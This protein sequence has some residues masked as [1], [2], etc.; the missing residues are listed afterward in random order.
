[1]H[2]SKRTKL[3]IFLLILSMLSGC[4]L[5]RPAPAAE[6]AESAAQTPEATEPAPAQPAVEPSA[7]P[8]QIEPTQVPLEPVSEQ[9]PKE[10][11]PQTDPE[12]ARSDGGKLIV[13]DPGHQ[14][15]GNYATEPLGPGSAE[16]KAKVSGGTAGVS[17]GLAEHELTLQV[18]LLLR[19]ELLARGYAVVLTR[20]T[21]DVDLSNVERAKIAND[22]QAD[23]FVRIHANGSEN[24]GASGAMTICMTKNSPYHPE[25]YDASYAL[26]AAI[27]DA[28]TAETGAKREYIWETDT[29]SGINWSE[30]P[31]TI[32]EMGYMTNPAEDRLLASAPYQA[33]IVT[34]IADGLDAYFSEP[35]PAGNDDPAEQPPQTDLQMLVQSELDALSSKWDVWVEDLSDGTS[36][37][38]FRNI[39]DGQSMVSASLIKLFIMGAVFDRIEAG[40]IAESEVAD[41]LYSM[42]TVSDNDAANSL[43]YLLGSGD[44]AEGRQAV[45]AWA[46]SIDCDDVRYN[47]LMLVDNGLQ[48]YVS[49]RSCAQIL[50]L[51]YQKTC[52]SKRASEKMLTLLEA[53][54]VNDRLPAQ[55]PA[56]AV[57]AHKTGNL[58]GLCIADVGIVELPDKPYLLCVICND[59]F[60]DDGATRKIA[61]L[62]LLIYHSFTES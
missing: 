11:A 39:S 19:D 60:T 2:I 41:R 44:A 15:I 30:V 32:L 47:R 53:Q 26:S 35:I 17:T 43:T 21:G 36:F 54:Q 18:S 13:I 48:N 16:M 5:R 56:S 4:S 6:A 34:G 24:A 49:A 20:E 31:V 10:Q 58:S 33:K 50:R 46:G 27:L 7:E 12:S 23:A 55:L 57:V 62:S 52:V 61:D 42:I 51:I 14:S 22:A 59:P 29:M 40:Q 9:P 45:E 25:L 28:F 3:L 38:C 1:M 37:H 8:R